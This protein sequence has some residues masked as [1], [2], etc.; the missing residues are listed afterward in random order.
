M[1]DLE[2]IQDRVR[3][4]VAS[5]NRDAFI[6]DLLRAY[7]FPK[8]SVTRLQS[9]NYNSAKV[10]GEILWKNRVYFTTAADGQLPH[11]C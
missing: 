2:V 1:K 11:Y 4:A 9:G 6:Y 3:D 10:E 7:G 5:P 8:A